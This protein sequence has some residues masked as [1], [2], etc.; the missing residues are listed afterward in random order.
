MA[1]CSHASGH[2]KHG[3]FKLQLKFN[4]LYEFIVGPKAT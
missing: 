2:S 4:F 1:E 3:C